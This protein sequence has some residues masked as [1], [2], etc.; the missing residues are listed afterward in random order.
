[1]LLL[2]RKL[3]VEINQ[4]ENGHIEGTPLGARKRLTGKQTYQP[5]LK[6][7]YIY[8]QTGDPFSVVYA[9]PCSLATALASTSNPCVIHTVRHR[10]HERAEACA[11]VEKV[12]EE[13]KTEK[14][15]R[16]QSNRARVEAEAALR[17]EVRTSIIYRW[18]NNQDR[19]GGGGE[20]VFTTSE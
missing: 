15:G 10:F 9:M 7:P 3:V 13:V 5:G 20:G 2:P 14:E 18:P 4:R 1:M 11:K 19:G 8:D 17:D 6:V 12:T 16:V